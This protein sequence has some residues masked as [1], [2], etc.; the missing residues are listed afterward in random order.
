MELTYG[1]YSWTLF[2]VNERRVLLYLYLK[3]LNFTSDCIFLI[4]YYFSMNENFNF[5]IFLACRLMV[6]NCR[7]RE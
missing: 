3:I 7:T 5:Y 4:E 2:G 6:A 1:H